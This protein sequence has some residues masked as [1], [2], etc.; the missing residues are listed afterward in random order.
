M[1]FNLAQVNDAVAT[2]YPD[3]E[4]F[5]WR[6]RRLSYADMAERTR[7][8]G[9]YLHD[10]GLGCHTERAQLEGWES[11]QDHL[12]LYM[13]NGNEYIEGMLGAYRARVA[14]FNVNYRYVEEE[15]RYLLDDSS[16]RAIVYHSEFAPTLEAVRAELPN[17]EVLIQVDDESDNSL[18]PDAVW[19]EDALA[20]SS[21]APVPVEPSPDDLY[22][23]YTGGTT[24]MPKGVLWRQGDIFPAALGGRDIGTGQEWADFDAIVTNA[25][26]GGARM[27]AAPPFMHGAAHW[28][29]FVALDWGNTVVLPSQTRSLDP[30]DIWQT[31]DRE[32]ANTLLIVGDAFGRPL[33]DELERGDYDLSSLL[34]LASGGAALSAPVKN[35][36][37]ELVPTMAIMD[38]LGSSETGTQA[39]QFSAAGAEATTGTF[40]PSFG[41]CIVSEDLSKRLEV[42]DTTLGWLAQ[43]GRV[44]LGYLGDQAKTERTFPVIDGIRYSVPGDRANYTPEG[45]LQLHGRDSVTINSGGE[46]IFAEEVEQALAQHP[47]VYDAVVTGRPSERW[48]NEVVAIVQLRPGMEVAEAEL[49][50]ECEKHIARYK[51]PKEIVLVDQVVRSPAGKADYRWAREQALRTT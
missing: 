16:A 51:L 13:Y 30:A 3:R 19:Y 34:M 45:Q 36:F 43:E 49:V 27:M 8:L 25:A 48:G 39:S 35:R 12:A 10:R 21:D 17:L 2:A 6:D 28:V 24:G 46:K 47:A 4:A 40:T 7:R 37:L 29:A 41:M 1:D 9:N 11:G 50:A 26:N 31:V 14:P 18:L 33:I 42:G 22:I 15:L 44:P 32:K 5:V 38:G 23:L 20:Q